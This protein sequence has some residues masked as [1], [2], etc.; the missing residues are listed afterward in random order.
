MRRIPR[1]KDEIASCLPYLSSFSPGLIQYSLTHTHTHSRFAV[2]VVV[3]VLKMIAWNWLYAAEV[4]KLM[5]LST[6]NQ[7]TDV[8]SGLREVSGKQSDLT[9]KS[10]KNF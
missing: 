10:C 1:G 2:T 3:V 4:V 5:G 6:M 8:S 7:T 9:Q